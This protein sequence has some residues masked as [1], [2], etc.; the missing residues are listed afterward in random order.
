[1]QT[2][3]ELMA[4]S[5]RQVVAEVDGRP[6]TRGELQEAFR[7]VSNKEHWKYPVRC[8]LPAE[9]SEHDVLMIEEAVAF[10]TGSIA[11]CHRFKNGKVRV[12]A[13]GYFRAI[14]A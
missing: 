2:H 3:E 5:N 1:M 8:T 9:T 13:D 4:E 12:T 10:F 14:G 7:K 6:V 11:I